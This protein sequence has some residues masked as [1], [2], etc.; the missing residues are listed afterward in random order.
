MAEDRE[1]LRE[2]W[3]GRLPVCFKLAEEEVYTMQQPEPYY[4]MIS[5]ISY[6]PLVVDKVHKHFSRHVDERYHGNEMWLE[7]N[8]QPLKWHLPIGV[9]YDCNASDSILPWGI[10]VHFQDFPEKQILH[11]GS[12][13]VVE[14]HFMS[15]IKEADMLKH[16][17]QVVSTMQKKD[18]N[19]LW[20]GLLNSKFD[21]FWAINKKFMERIGGE[22]FKHIPFRLYMPDGSLIQRLVTPLTPSGDKATL[23]T[24]LQQVVPQALVGGDVA[25]FLISSDGAKH[26]IITHGI[27]VPLDT[28]LQWMSEHLSY[29]DNFLHLCVMPCS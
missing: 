12:R 25:S 9:L 19:Q 10:T 24:L 22:C 14:S 16:R 26:S 4:L 27:Q 13:A 18:H 11:C 1:V 28:P 15:A 17:S 2:I 23:E 6:F 7:Y 29:P 21:Q 20:V 5:R 3:D 8:G